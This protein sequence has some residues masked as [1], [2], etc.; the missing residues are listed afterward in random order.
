MK[1]FFIV[2]ALGM[3][4]AACHNSSTQTR[5][6]DSFYPNGQAKK[7]TTYKINGTD[8]IAIQE[9]EYHSTGELKMEGMLQDGQRE[10][11]WKSWYNNGQLWSIGTYAKGQRI[12][13]ALSYFPNGQVRMRGYYSQGKLVGIWKV[14]NE[15]G[16]LI[17]EKDYG[18]Q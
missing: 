3:S 10:G 16:A 4:I 5:K 15:A 12:D 8:S 6:V 2:I 9:Q 13:S 17:G 14:Y 11:V 1:K 7:V 18:R